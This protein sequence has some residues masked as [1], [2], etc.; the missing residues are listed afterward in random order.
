M[1]IM[2]LLFLPIEGNVFKLLQIHGFTQNHSKKTSS[3]TSHSQICEFSDSI[4]SSSFLGPQG[5][6]PGRWSRSEKK[7][8]SSCDM[9]GDPQDHPHPKIP[10]TICNTV[11]RNRLAPATPPASQRLLALKTRSLRSHL[12]T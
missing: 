5:Q 10:R 12:S 4:S 2:Y 8:S 11:V 7:T 1:K 3:K 6:S 9:S